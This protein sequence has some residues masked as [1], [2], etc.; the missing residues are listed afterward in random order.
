MAHERTGIALSVGPMAS[1]NGSFVETRIR[2]SND[3]AWWRSWLSSELRAACGSLHEIPSRPADV[4]D[5]A[6]GAL[7]RVETANTIR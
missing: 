3:G 6:L 4:L 1:V 7:A 5:G 2:V